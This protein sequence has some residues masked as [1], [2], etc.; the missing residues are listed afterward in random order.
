MS[1]S[2]PARL[3]AAFICLA[4]LVAPFVP[5]R[6]AECPNL[7][8][9]GP[10]TTVGAPRFSKGPQKITAFAVDPRVPRNMFVTNG[11]AVMRTTNSGCTFKQVFV[12]PD[13]PSLE[14]Q[15]TAANS[16][17][18]SIDVSEA[19]HDLVYLLIDEDLDGSRRTHVTVS[20]T[21]GDSWRTADL[22]LPP[23]GAPEFLVPAPSAAAVAYVG[24]DVGG[25]AV[26]YHFA[27][28]DMGTTWTLRSDLA[29]T[30]P[31]AGVTG[32]TADPIDETSLWAWGSSTPPNQAGQS[33]G[34]E[35]SGLLHS[36]DGGRTFRNVDDFTGVPAGPVDVFHAAGEAARIVAFIPNQAATS[37]STDGG[38]TW[39]Q[40]QSPPAYPVDAAT[41]LGAAD[42]LAASAR[43]EVFFFHFPTFQ[44]VE[45]DPPTP[46]LRNVTADRAEFRLYA[47]STRAIDVYDGRVDVPP[48]R[49]LG[50]IFDV[51]LV[52][53][54][55]TPVRHDP[56][57]S[58]SRRIALDAGDSTTA[59]YRL[60][61]PDRPLPL[62]VFFLLDTSDSMGATIEDLAEAVA[63]I[64]NRLAA[65]DIRLKVGI[66]AF[67]AYPDRMPPDPPCGPTG[68]PGPQRCEKNYVFE[69]VLQIAPPGPHVTTALETLDSDAG[70]FY[71][72]HLGALYQLA[73]GAGQDLFPPGPTP[74]DV[75]AGQ[76]ADWDKKALKVV[77]MATDERFW[78]GQARD[79]AGRDLGSP[80]TPATPLFDDVADA[81]D[82]PGTLDDIYQV[83]LSIGNAPRKDLQKVARMTN[84]VAPP[85]GV[86][87]DGDGFAEIVPGEP[88]V[89][90][91][92]RNNLNDSHNLVPAIVNTLQAIPKS[93]DVTLTVR[94]KEEV[95]RKVSPSV[96]RNVVEQI[97][98]E[99]VYD[100]DYRC[101]L[102]VAGK[103]F[104]IELVA[105]DA[106]GRVLDETTTKIVCG[107]VESP[108]VLPLPL[109][110]IFPPVPPPPPPPVSNVS[111][112]SQAQG[113]A[114]AQAGAAYQEEEQPQVAVAAA[115][116]EMLE[117]RAAMEYEMV[118]YERRRYP[119]SP[120][121]VLGAGFLMGACAYAVA[122]SRGRAQV[123]R[124]RN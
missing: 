64:T 67:R 22:G 73:T 75:D 2:I 53:G 17:I 61:L 69:N 25:G 119:V 101:P 12:L 29:D 7:L 56:V 103:S 104:P 40:I 122:L 44:W 111:S 80:E 91:V 71:K 32:M 42:T 95:I 46:G 112:S 124:Q 45:L 106:T 35:A 70:G 30:K 90:D 16:V 20:D 18:R 21:G 62:N 43:G 82:R 50:R 9:R 123:A 78:R 1:R 76:Q 51:S 47:H 26:D 57:L 94:G 27:T 23:N 114:Q 66:G 88:L 15:A 37:M 6:A 120:S 109:I 19:N 89:C 3:A 74:N 28:T 8:R 110:A 41:H 65:E 116:K 5:A 121:I 60:D 118:A 84:T 92:R 24:I 58:G 96:H 81:F 59:R 79:S 72:S 87:C 117:Q 100:V 98:N 36:T 77:V 107:D 54:Q 52:Q 85:Q 39:A 31:N 14:S 102:S 33:T 68:G 115:Y 108:A 10:W 97:A 48:P 93:T 34:R 113:Q 83:G 49:D 105:S 4:T 38:E 63:Q 86:D 13:G 99:L 55:G 11:T